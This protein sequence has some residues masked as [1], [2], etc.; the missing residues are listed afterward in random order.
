VYRVVVGGRRWLCCLL[1]FWGC[2]RIGYEPLGNGAGDSGVGDDAANPVDANPGPR[3]LV[4]TGIDLTGLVALWT[5]E[6]QSAS[7]GASFP[8]FPDPSLVAI[9]ETND[10]SDVIDVGKVGTA[11]HLDGSDDRL[12]VADDPALDIAGPQTMTVWIHM[13]QL[14]DNDYGLVGKENAYTLE[15]EG[16]T[17]CIDLAVY[18][19]GGGFDELAPMGCELT[20]N[21]WHHLAS[22][23]DGTDL[24]VYQ[25]G[26]VV[27]SLPYSGA[28][29]LV[30]NDPVLIGHNSFQAGRYMD[31]R[32][33]EVTIW[34][35]ALTSA[36]IETIERLQR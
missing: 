27:G 28:A 3:A 4:D 21:T 34:S 16:S 31:G 36:E 24:I 20:A 15:I 23:Y 35:R 9:L 29:V 10:M 8:A 22:V 18:L 6:A 33:D 17:D 19:P 32:L 25:N 26:Q 5:F 13:D 12:V 30:N 2:G 7:E 14:S 1:L 11:V